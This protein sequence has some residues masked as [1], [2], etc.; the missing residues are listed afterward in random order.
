M[1]RELEGRALDGAREQ[2]RCLSLPV[3]DRETV[4]AL[5]YVEL[6]AHS[7]GRLLDMLSAHD[8]MVPP[9]ARESRRHDV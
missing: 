7:F 6:R 2:A 8:R 5:A 1:A 9:V 4:Q 3:F